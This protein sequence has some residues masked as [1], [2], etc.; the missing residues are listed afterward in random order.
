ML[1][2]RPLTASD[3]FYAVAQIYT[4]SWKTAYQG[5]VPQRYLDKLR[6]ESWIGL[7]KADPQANLVALLDDQVIGTAFVS[8]ARDEARES[9]GEL[10]GLY[11]LSALTGMGYGRQ[12]WQAAVEH[13]RQ[14][15]LSGLCLW[16]LSG[17]DHACRFYERMGMQASGRVKTEAI[18]GEMLPLTEYILWLDAPSP[19]IKQGVERP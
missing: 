7:L 8:Y 16:V 13:C 10:V 3:D 12:L 19:T 15:G 14:Q 4:D 5:L 9:F 17:N 2:I 6:P 11:L 1:I 18:G